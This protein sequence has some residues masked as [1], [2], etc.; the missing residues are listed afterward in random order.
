MRN[1]RY[2]RHYANDAESNT[3]D[4]QR[5]EVAFELCVSCLSCGL[6]AGQRQAGRP[7]LYPRLANSSSSL[8]SVSLLA[9]ASRLDPMIG[10]CA[11][12]YPTT[13]W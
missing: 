12:I 5:R 7:C 6:G 4:F 1:I 8:P 2:R 11:V 13:R 10:F 9:L 3:K